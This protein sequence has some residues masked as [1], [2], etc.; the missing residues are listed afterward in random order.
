MGYCTSTT[1]DVDEIMDIGKFAIKYEEPRLALEWMTAAS[2]ILTDID[3]DEEK[4]RK[5]VKSFSI[6]CAK[7][8]KPIPAFT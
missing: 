4:S 6:K 8:L 5:K 3:V 2:F 7:W 1:L